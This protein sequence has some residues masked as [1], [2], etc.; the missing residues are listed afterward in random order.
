M[1]TVELSLD[2]EERKAGVD[3]QQKLSL[4]LLFGRQ[5]NREKDCD[6]RQ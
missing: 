1:N 3:A 4:L 2:A 6:R 5:T